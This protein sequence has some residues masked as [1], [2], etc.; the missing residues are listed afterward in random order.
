M[1]ET[2]ARRALFQGAAAIALGSAATP[3]LPLERAYAQGSGTLRVAMTAA[4]VPLPNGQT[5]QGGEGQRF[6]GYTLF[7]SLILWDLSRADAPSRL[8][9]GLATEWKPDASDP[10]RWVFTLRQGVKFH[11]GS[12]FTADAVVWNLEKILNQSAPQFDR[13]QATQGRGRI[14]SIAPGAYK[15]LDRY[16]VE[17]RTTSPNALLPYELCWIVMSSPA[18]WEKVGRSWDNF[19]REPSGTGPWKLTQYSPRERAVL[20]PN[21]EYWNEA[22]RPK[23]SQLVLIPMPESSTRTAA[24]R[25]GQ[26]DWVEAPAPDTLASLR[27]AGFQI[28]T[29]S[30]PHTWIWHLSRIEG[31]P[32]NDLRVRQAANLAIDRAGIAEL[33]AGTMEP[34]RGMLPPSSPWFGNPAFKVRHDVAEARK[35]MEAAGFSRARP[36]AIKAQIPSSG[37][38]MMQPVPMNEAIQQGLSEAHFR[39]EFEVLEWNAQTTSWRAGA[40][41][42]EARGASAHNNSYF[43]QDPFTG[44][45]RHLRSDLVSP[46][47]TNWGHY[48]DPEMDALFTE[49]ATSFD[50]AKQ[51]AACIRAHEKYVNEALFLFVGHDLNARAMSRRVQGFVQAQNWFQ[52]LTPVRMG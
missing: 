12:E 1:A 45:I 25:A 29:N 24:L 11:D 20:V 21:A 38:G 22:R 16:S 30:Y 26:V 18:Q 50:Q 7:D 27:Q 42:P 37:S 8:V 31:S 47:G 46:R 17:I 10:S 39:V 40:R 35:L 49:I 23:L 9:P 32:W 15:A 52:D 34:A 13:N 4:A 33:L 36:L 43:S 3:M 48:S 51:D 19:L 28:V 5:D 14:P 44:L 6:I 41:A 2:L